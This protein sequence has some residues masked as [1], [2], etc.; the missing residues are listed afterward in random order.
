MLEFY[1]CRAAANIT[2]KTMPKKIRTALTLLVT[3]ALLCTAGY[4]AIR[5]LVPDIFTPKTTAQ[6]IKSAELKAADKKHI[7]TREVHVKHDG[8]N[9][10]GKLTAPANYRD[11][12][13]PLIIMSHGYDSNADFIGSASTI[14][15]SQGYML[16]SFDFYGGGNSTRSGNTDMTK[17]SIN[18]EKADLEAVLSYWISQDFVDTSHIYLSGVSHGGLISSMVAASHPNDIKAMIL[19]A[20]AFNV[21]DVVRTGFK[22]LHLTSISQVPATITYHGRTVGKRYVTDALKLDVTATQRA[23]SGPVLI[24]HGTADAVVPYSYSQK[25]AQTFLNARLVPVKDAEHSADMS[26]AMPAIFEI[27]AFLKKH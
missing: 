14:I 7:V 25:A 11:Q 6:S 16:Y 2:L 20:P 21:P 19:I 1:F 4:G 13:L 5:F 26:S 27:N 18:T 15:A 9:L 22:E 10:Y 24:I 8:I 17:M 3:L 12:H 23:Y